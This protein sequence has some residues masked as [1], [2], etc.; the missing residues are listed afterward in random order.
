M[1]IVVRSV[2]AGDVLK[3]VP[4][5]CVSAMIVDCLHGAA[6]IEQNGH[7]RRHHADFVSQPCARGVQNETLHR[8]VV[9]RA[10]CV[11]HVEAVVTSM[12]VCCKMEMS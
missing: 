2:V 7:A 3:R 1:D 12:P 9:K 6:N 11:W 8:M 5:Q 4:G 10:V